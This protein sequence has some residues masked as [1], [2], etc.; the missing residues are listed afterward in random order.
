MSHPSPQDHARAEDDEHPAVA[1]SRFV[2][3]GGAEFVVYGED[4]D[5]DGA[6]LSGAGA[7]AVAGCSVAG[8]EDFSGDHVGCYVWAC[9]LL[10]RAH[11]EM[12]GIREN[13]RVT[14]RS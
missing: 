8:W 9:C 7:D 10:V 11:G 12:R 2:A 13:G 4:L 1:D 14:N 3:R 5:E 6:E